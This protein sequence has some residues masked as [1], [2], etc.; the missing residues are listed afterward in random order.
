MGKLHESAAKAYNSKIEPL[1]D[2][3]QPKPPPAMKPVESD[4][5]PVMAKLDEGDI[6][7]ASFREYEIDY[8]GERKACYFHTSRGALGVSGT[9]HD[10]LL[11]VVRRIAN[12]RAYC[13]SVS[14]KFVYERTID[15]FR[16]KVE[17]PAAT[18]AS[19]TDFVEEAAARAITRFE[20]WLP[21]PAVQIT[22][23]FQIGKTKFRRITKAMMDDWVTRSGVESSAKTEA[24]FDRLRSRIQNTTAACVEVEAEPIRAN[25]IALRESEGSIAILRLACPAMMNV[26]QWAPLDPSFIDR[27]GAPLI[28]RVENSK[29]MGQHSALHERM[30]TQWV[31]RPE[32][33]EYYF[34]TL[35]GFGHNLLVIQRNEFQDLLLGALIHYSKSVLKSDPAERLLYIITALESIFIKKDEGIVQ[36][37][38]ERMA[39]MM[40]P[41]AGKRLKVLDVISK[42]YE[43]RSGFVHR[44]APIYEISILEEFFL[45]A[46]T[47]MFFLLNNYNKWDTKTE[48]LRTVDAHKFSG[49]EFSTATI[50]NKPPG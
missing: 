46:W 24:H 23:P 3:V 29:I 25:E 5:V 39:V 43:I 47:T 28:L 30:M 35:W 36:N 41:G 15:W 40:E 45:E 48:F 10:V 21:I 50:P 37:L 42:V 6:E 34:Q 13:D 16:N 44:A 2:R 7:I 27:M 18:H 19:F 11:Q 31:L 14:E 26:Y 49:P 12:D 1:V 20:V 38:R 32:E 17:N 8:T 22:R 4:D 33:I 9:D